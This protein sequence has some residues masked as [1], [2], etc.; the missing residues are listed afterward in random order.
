[1][2]IMENETARAV[3]VQTSGAR[4]VAVD[5]PR[6]SLTELR[7]LLREATAYERAQRPIVLHGPEQP[8]RAPQ[9]T[10]AGHEGIDVTV[11][12]A[13]EAP[14]LRKSPLRRLYTGAEAAYM[15]CAAVLGTGAVS[16][17]AELLG[18]PIAA[19][20]VPVAGALGCLGF[21]AA[22]NRDED[23][24]YRARVEEM[25][26]Y[27]DAIEAGTAPQLR[28]MPNMPTRRQVPELT[29]QARTEAG[30]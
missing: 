25:R 26:A 14:A 15:V 4:A 28:L 30:R 5:E 1:M 13:P 7:Q 9:T 17:I 2:T 16:G 12:A 22:M 21:A 20:A 19:G 24:P 10:V 23:R 8:A 3:D 6:L 18:G 11:P 29:A 27:Q